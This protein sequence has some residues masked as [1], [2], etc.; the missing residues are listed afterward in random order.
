[1]RSPSGLDLSVLD[2]GG[3]GRVLFCLHGHFGQA[4]IYHILPPVLPGWRVIALDQRG[5]GFSDHAATYRREDYAADALAVLDALGVARAVVLG[6]SLGGVNAYQLAARHGDRVAGLVVE[7]IGAVCRDDL[8]WCLGWPRRF[9]SLHAMQA[10]IHRYFCESAVQRADG[11]DFRFDRPGMVAS[12]A[13]LNGDWWADWLASR[14]PAL[15]LRGGDSNILPAALA[16]EMVARRP[17]TTLRVFPG[18]GHNI[19][20]ADPAGY[21]QAVADFLATVA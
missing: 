5:H 13:S 19:N 3:S 6:S 7:D 4:A 14:C 1:M 12:G 18:V 17:A 9:P 16:D 2:W 11:W 20:E 8:S 10:Q 15:L 21:A